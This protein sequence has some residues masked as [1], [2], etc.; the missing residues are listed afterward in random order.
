MQ[1]EDAVCKWFTKPPQ[2]WKSEQGRARRGGRVRGGMRKLSHMW[3]SR[4]ATRRG[5]A[6]AVRVPDIYARRVSRKRVCGESREN[7][8]RLQRPCSTLAR[9]LLL[10]FVFVR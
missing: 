2:L 4:R 6:L 8:P 5:E 9:A 10:Y 3:R 7:V 1:Q